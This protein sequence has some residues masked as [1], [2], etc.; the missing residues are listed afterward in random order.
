MR[1]GNVSLSLDFIE[2][3]RYSFVS[4]QSPGSSALWW[5]EYSPIGLHNVVED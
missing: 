2:V 1:T 5:R 3:N 4:V